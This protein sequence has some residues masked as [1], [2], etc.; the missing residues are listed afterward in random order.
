VGVELSEEELAGAALPEGFEVDETAAYFGITESSDILNELKNIDRHVALARF[1]ELTAD[2]HLSKEEFDFSA[3]SERMNCEGGEIYY[4]VVSH[5]GFSAMSDPLRLFLGME[6]SQGNQ[7]TL[8]EIPPENIEALSGLTD[9]MSL[10]GIMA[11]AHL[12]SGQGMV[13]TYARKLESLL[14][15]PAANIAALIEITQGYQSA[16]SNAAEGNYPEPIASLAAGGE[17]IISDDGT[18]QPS[19][20]LPS[21]QPAESS[22]PA[23]T[24]PPAPSPVLAPSPAMSGVTPSP[25]EQSEE[26]NV[27]LPSSQ[28]PST[29]VPTVQNKD[30]VPLPV[31]AETVSRPPAVSSEVPV[32]SL[33]EKQVAV[34]AD[35]VFGDAFGGAI[36]VEESVP[37]QPETVST[38]VAETPAEPVLVEEETSEAVTESIPQPVDDLVTEVVE[39]SVVEATAGKDAETIVEDIGTVEE[40]ESISSS[41]PDSILPSKGEQVQTFLAADTDGDGRLSEEEIVGALGDSETAQALFDTADTDGDGEI[42]LPEFI[43]ATK[44]D[45]TSTKSESAPSGLP[46]PVAPKRAPV[47]QSSAGGES[48]NPRVAQMAGFDFVIKSGVNCGSCGIGI[49]PH[50]RYCVVCGTSK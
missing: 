20:P 12:T 45:A 42:T 27:P 15:N 50:W 36:G 39:E 22:A 34:R 46:R 2:L 8:P 19:V 31:E 49:D 14:V 30:V 1:I 44:P 13:V 32:E 9:A 29:A 25:I 3:A 37:V 5:F 4:L 43:E 11:V 35:N 24:S 40:S 18:S 38:P 48:P 23:A 21:S 16:L 6:D 41:V 28:H 7:G 17:A 10:L 26:E 47:G 33:T